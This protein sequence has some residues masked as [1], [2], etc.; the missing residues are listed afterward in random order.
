MGMTSLRH[1]V[2]A[3]GQRHAARLPAGGDRVGAAFTLWAAQL[4]ELG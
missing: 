4:Q 2:G 1:T 3:A